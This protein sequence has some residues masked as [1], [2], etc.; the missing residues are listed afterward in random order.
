MFS[1]TNKCL[2]L[3]TNKK[4][5]SL[6]HYLISNICIQVW[7]FVQ[8]AYNSIWELSPTSVTNTFLELGTFWYMVDLYLPYNS[9]SNVSRVVSQ[10][11]IKLLMYSMISSMTRKLLGSFLIAI[12]LG[13]VLMN[14]KCLAIHF[15]DFSFNNGLPCMNPSW[16]QRNLCWT[17]CGA[18]DFEIG[19]L[20]KK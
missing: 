14:L 17:S 10:L 3:Q 2:Y 5:H 19:R 20:F 8:F 4:P 12:Q 9:N 16:N 11:L 6:N 15:I 7:G 1:Q 18:D 13:Q